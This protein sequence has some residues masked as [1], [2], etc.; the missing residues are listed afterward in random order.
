MKKLYSIAE[1][2]SQEFIVELEFDALN[3]L[4]SPLSFLHSPSSYIL[5]IPS[6]SL[7]QFDKLRWMVSVAIPLWHE[8]THETSVCKQN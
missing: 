2:Y 7:I 6:L 8:T 1:K 5:S 4:L 3:L